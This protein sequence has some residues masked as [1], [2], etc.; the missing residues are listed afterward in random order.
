MMPV[1]AERAAVLIDSQMS[2]MMPLLPLAGLVIGFFL[3]DVFI[4]LRPWTPWFLSMITFSGVLKLRVTE[5]GGVLRKPIPIFCFFIL[6][7]ILTPLYVLFFSSIFFAGNSETIAGFILLYSAP[8]A[9]S[10]F[11]WITT[12]RGNMALGLSLILFDT[13]LSPIF[14]PL[15]ISVLAGSKVTMDPG[16]I[17][18]SLIFTVVIPTILGIMLN[19]TSRGKIP[20]LIS[21]YFNPLSK[22]SLMLIIAANASSTLPAIQFNDQK[23]WKIAGLCITLTILTMLTARLAGFITRCDYEKSVALVFTIGQ[24]NTSAAIIIATSFFPEA[25]ALPALIN[26]LFQQII[27]GIMGNLLFRKNLE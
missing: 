18:I 26:I 27:S 21:P 20:A 6:S 8:A 1:K 11:I 15:S 23:I 3:P 22:F 5:L 9:A 10:G 2:R 4:H 7:R 12:F 25:F 17:M 19:E 13:L 24:R 14:M 16:S